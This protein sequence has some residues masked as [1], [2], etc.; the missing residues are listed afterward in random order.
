M[1]TES[2]RPSSR[3]KAGG[4]DFEAPDYLAL[5]GLAGLWIALVLAVDPRGNFPLLD[6]WSYG[7]SVKILIEQGKL[8]Y[9]GWNAATLFFQVIYGAL[10]SLPF[11][12]SF[13]ALRVSTLVAGLAGSLGTYALLRETS[14]GRGVAFIGSLVVA[15]NPVYFQ[16]AFTFMTDV[17][18]TAL[19]VLSAF[20]YL[21]ALHT[22][23]ARD[24]LIGTLLA[25][26]ATLVRQ[27]GIA[28]PF[29]YGV[30]LLATQAFRKDTLLRSAWPL[31]VVLAVLLA[32]QGFIDY[33]HMTAP[34]HGAVEKSIL[35]NIEAQGVAAVAL[36]A[37][38]LGEALFVYLALIAL[39]FMIV[40]VGYVSWQ[41]AW[42][43]IQGRWLIVAAPA[44]LLV[45]A[46]IFWPP[47]LQVQP[48]EIAHNLIPGQ[49]PWGAGGEPTLFRQAL[50][51][52]EFV[53]TAS[54]A[55]MLARV[56]VDFAKHRASTTSADLEAVLFGVT[57]SAV[58]LAPFVL[59]GHFF[60]RYL[61]PIVPFVLL[62]LL[63]LMKPAGRFRLEWKPALATAAAVALLGA[64]GTV[65]VVFAH[66]FFI[67][68][69]VRWDAVNYLVRTGI[70]P[71][72]IDGGISVNG[73]Y[74]FETDSQ[75]RKR[76]INW[77][78]EEGK[79]WRNVGADYVIGYPRRDSLKRLAEQSGTLAPGQPQI[80]WQKHYT[81]WLPRADG[82]IVICRGTAC[83]E[84][85]Y[86]LRA[87]GKSPD[88][89]LAR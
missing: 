39:P 36:S 33:L 66:D 61:I 32:Y 64:Y 68:N 58:M 89:T 43:P 3:E 63:A 20:F 12:F 1:Q 19:A 17:P 45:L 62:V 77:R 78:T 25:S 53:A 41:N 46:W 27:T 35:N 57:A 30:A 83:P 8:H 80:I 9:D 82:A 5:L 2:R 38:R 15:L 34:L 7:R 54:L 18:F 13:E 50:W 37:L 22:G 24:A 26:C 28:L 75:L 76:Y 86:P 47:A 60:E 72:R 56:A 42:P 71:S 59:A 73:W 51:L 29:A 70:T 65:S 67:W 44:W 84:L 6:D 23:S 4:Q 85:F 88:R 16:H 81:G 11:G 74:L 79:W 87:D 52:L 21:R 31:G 48:F 69:R 49:R 40:L 10:F 14:A 55:G